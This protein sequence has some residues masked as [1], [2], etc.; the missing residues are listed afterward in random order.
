MTGLD[1]KAGFLAKIGDTMTTERCGCEAMK[2]DLLLDD[3]CVKVQ[4]GSAVGG[5]TLP[6]VLEGIS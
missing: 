4:F 1:Y 3:I 6:L 2:S 5:H